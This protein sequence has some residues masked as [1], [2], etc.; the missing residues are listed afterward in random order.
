M[1]ASS[2]SVTEGEGTHWFWSLFSLVRLVAD[3]K[4]NDRKV[5][6]RLQTVDE[7][8]NKTLD[9]MFQHWFTFAWTFTDIK[10]MR[11]VA[12]RYSVQMGLAA[13]EYKVFELIDKT[14]AKTN[15]EDLL[16]QMVGIAQRYRPSDYFARVLRGRVRELSGDVIGSMADYEPGSLNVGAGAFEVFR[17]GVWL[18]DQKQDEAERLFRLAIG[19]EPSFSLAYRAYADCVRWRN[20]HSAAANYLAGLEHMPRLHYGGA[21]PSV[22]H[23]DL[24]ALGEYR[25]FVLTIKGKK[26][27]AYPA[28]SGDFDL[29]SERLTWT[30]RRLAGLLLLRLRFRN[31]LLR[32]SYT[33]AAPAPKPPHRWWQSRGRVAKYR[34]RL[35]RYKDLPGVE[36]ARFNVY[37]IRKLVRILVLILVLPGRISA[38]IQLRIMEL[39]RQAAQQFVA[40]AGRNY[41]LFQFMLTGDSLDDLK[42]QID[43]LHDCWLSTDHVPAADLAKRTPLIPIEP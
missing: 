32:G 3:L 15:Y 33:G 6:R 21:N 19:A 28:A 22:G 16:N 8:I 40:W 11:Q 42:E 29:S 41:H 39:E 38:R 31:K 14:I 5:A 24:R 1:Q 20:P 17:R 43:L 10:S 18:R 23:F 2:R 7:E 27:I 25:N 13:D 9:E 36:T 26:Y 35:A 30:S 4:K 12:R 34:R 37:L